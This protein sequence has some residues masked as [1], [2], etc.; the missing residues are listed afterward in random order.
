[1]AY[2]GQQFDALM[3]SSTRLGNAI[4]ITIFVLSKLVN[5]Y[6]T[7]VCAIMLPHAN[8]LTSHIVLSFN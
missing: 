7:L 5:L 4:I 1:M 2:L 6:I 8:L 3:T